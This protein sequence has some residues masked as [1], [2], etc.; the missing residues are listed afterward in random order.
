MTASCTLCKLHKISL[1]NCVPGIG[2][3]DSKILLLGEAL[4]EEEELLQKP[5]VGQA[6][7]LLN[8]LLI[9]AGLSR[10]KIFITNVVRCRPVADS[11]TRRGNRTPDLE[12][13]EAC[14]SHLDKEIYSIKPNV[15]IVAGNVALK[16]ILGDSSSNITK[17]R[18]EVIWSEKY[19]C[20]VVPIVHPAALLRGSRLI[21]ATVEDLKRALKNSLTKEM[22]TP[23][24]VQY[25]PLN[26]W[27]EVT[28]LL[29]RLKQPDI[30]EISIDVE[31]SG[32]DWLR[33]KIFSIGFSWK[34]NTGVSLR[35]RDENLNYL[36]TN[37]QRNEIVSVLQKYIFQNPNIV[38]YGHNLKFDEHMIRQEG[39]G[40]IYNPKYDTLLMHHLIDSDSPHGLK[41]LAR[42]YTDMGNYEKPLEEYFETLGRKERQYHKA[43]KELVGRYNA[44]DCDCTIRLAHT[45]W[46]KIK[47]NR[48]ESTLD[49]VMKF[50]DLTRDAEK[51]GMIVDFDL[52]RKL[53]TERKGRIQEI[54]KSFEKLTGALVNLRSV[55]QLNNL[56]FTVLKWI[57][58]AGTKGKTGYSLN[59]E[60]LE[61]YAKDHDEAKL[62]LEFRGLNTDINTYLKGIKN[63][64]IFGKSKVFSPETEKIV[65]KELT[66]SRIVENLKES[67]E[68]ST[69]DWKAS[70]KKELKEAKEAEDEERIEDLEGVLKDLEDEVDE[71]N[72]RKSKLKKELSDL[73]EKVWSIEEAKRYG[74]VTDGRVHTDLLVH[75]TS[76]GRLS[77]RNPNLQNIKRGST[78]RNIFI[79]PKG[80]KLIDADFAQAEIRVLAVCS[81]DP[82]LIKDLND[83]LD[84]HRSVASECYGVPL[85]AVT[86]LQ[87]NQAKTV[88][89]G[90][91]YGITA[92]SI[93]EQH[94][95]SEEDAQRLINKFFKKYPFV[96]IFIESIKSKVRKDK[97]VTSVFGRKRLFPNIDGPNRVARDDAE[98]EAVNFVIQSVASDLTLL[99][100]CR[101][102][103]RIKQ[104]NLKS[105]FVLPV[106]DAL[107]FYVP[108]NEVAIL[109]NLLQEEMTKRILHPLVPFNIDIHVYNRWKEELV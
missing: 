78:I 4:G 96:D 102:T 55:K 34:E 22:S 90:I 83:G 42:I 31:T 85:E 1:A 86:D 68:L 77:S 52:M 76:T 18:G 44:A 62:L 47:E 19:Q 106:H 74:I 37:E 11:T 63:S 14:S 12:E 79:A 103:E 60:N 21:G 56:F 66:E 41:D 109:K 98:R 89:F 49:M 2:P 73:R 64:V 69:K 32:V 100:A 35:W 29:N 82:N 81:K 36:W 46:P 93:S 26:T 20:K 75:G 88:V 50:S 3:L 99:A 54:E 59:E 104:M 80:C 67:T 61:I 58:L 23:S 70:L 13:I 94:G 10:E 71:N 48:M 108:D 87:R 53:V 40:I 95:I 97:F 72:I 8:K 38:K 28:E 5:F 7:K 39:I 101:I 57:P 91:A 65:L 45:L 25:V 92:K 105:E 33:D 9:D 30:T 17:V 24:Q 43:P 16:R 15:I 107:M 84:I 6:G 27:D 51:T